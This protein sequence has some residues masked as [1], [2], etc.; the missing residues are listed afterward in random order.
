MSE[1]AL[2]IF[3]DPLWPL[4]H[5]EL[6]PGRM[7]WVDGD[8]ALWLPVVFG[9]RGCPARDGKDDRVGTGRSGCL[10]LQLPWQ[11]MLFLSVFLPS[12]PWALGTVP[13]CLV[14]L[15][16]TQTFADRPCIKSSLEDPSL[17]V[18]FVS[19]WE[20]DCNYVFNSLYGF[21][22][23]HLSFIVRCIVSPQKILFMS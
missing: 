9:Q 19:C 13:A 17:R 11:T 6:W 15:Y 1:N 10:L 12:A 20:S 2:L 14:F 22:Y 7:T 3:P 16:P 21:M 23:T 5:S 8:P 4:L 18:P